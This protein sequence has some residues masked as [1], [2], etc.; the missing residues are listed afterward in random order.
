MLRVN[1]SLKRLNFFFGW[2]EREELNYDN[3]I[4]IGEV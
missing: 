4:N 3:V 2:E 1:V